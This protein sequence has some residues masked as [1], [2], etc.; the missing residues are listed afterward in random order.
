M[1]TQNNLM[2]E[3]PVA[4]VDRNL[5]RKDRLYTRQVMDVLAKHQTALKCIYMLGVGN[6][7]TALTQP[8]FLWLADRCGLVDQ[9]LTAPDGIHTQEL[10]LVHVSSPNPYAVNSFFRAAKRASLTLAGWLSQVWSQMLVADEIKDMG[11]YTELSF[12]DFMEA[13]AR[14][15][16]IKYLFS[17]VQFV[18]GF[19]FTSNALALS[20]SH[21]HHRSFLFCFCTAGG[22]RDARHE[23][24]SGS[25]GEDRVQRLIQKTKGALSDVSHDSLVSA[26]CSN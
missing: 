11:N 9:H 12:I 17:K 14:V 8:A 2:R 20:T 13:L 21:S 3:A 19:W 22:A 25:H 5:F 24:L 7:G 18:E 23:A 1:F 26:S 16:D 10:K 6:V 15:A 4:A